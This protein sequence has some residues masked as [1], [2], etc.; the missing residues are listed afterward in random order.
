MTRANQKHGRTLLVTGASGFL[1]WHVCR[2]AALS[3][4]VVGTYCTHATS[5]DGVAMHR[6][7]LTG[8]ELTAF[9]N[10]L[11][12]DT[13][14][15]A[16]ALSQPN[17][18]ESDPVASERVNVVSTQNIAE[19]CGKHDVPMVFTSSDLVFDGQHAPYDEASATEPAS[20]YGRH[21]L[22]AEE[23]VLSRVPAGVVCRLPLMFGD[24]DGAPASFIGPWLERLAKG[25]ALTLFEDEIRT[26]VSGMVAANGLLL[27]L[28][29]GAR[30]ILHLGGGER[31]SRY[32]FGLKL[33]EIFGLS[34]TAIQ[35]AKICDIKMSAPRPPD[36]SLDSG[37]AFALGYAPGTLDMQLAA[38]RKSRSQ[39]VD[40]DT[41]N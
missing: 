5:I 41:S 27:A 3:W 28:S 11:Q 8:G 19:W 24:R 39:A 35:K 9:L 29:K 15:H 18:C 6:L 17:A 13:I 26:P 34:A 7:D 40:L 38:V 23:A 33:A 12:P 25:E 37:K 14:V 20:I 16:A 10:D 2:V 22:A 30:G 4:N 36:V 1:G 32:A 31:I 21:K